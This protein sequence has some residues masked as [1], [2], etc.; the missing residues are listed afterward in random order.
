MQHG[1]QKGHGSQ[2]G[3]DRH[4]SHDRDR[5]RNFGRERHRHIGRGDIRFRDG[6]REIFFGGLWFG[7][8]VYPA[9]VF[10]ED[11][12]VECIDGEY[13]VYSYARPNLSV[14]VIVVE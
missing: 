8:D 11:V 10:S 4:E 9:W 13:F 14:R 2:H 1:K 5:N 6:R 12:Y 3:H 7:C